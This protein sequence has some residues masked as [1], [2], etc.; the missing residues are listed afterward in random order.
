[1][2]TIKQE[3][4]R[5]LATD[6]IARTALGRGL[7]NMNGYAKTVHAEINERLFKPVSIASLVTTLSRL[8]KELQIQEQALPAINPHDI[9]IKSNLVEIS[10]YQHTSITDALLRLQKWHAEQARGFLTVIMGVREIT[11]IT[12]AKLAGDIMRLTK[13]HAPAL[14]LQ[15]LAAITLQVG[16]SAI[17]TP[18]VTYSILRRLAL[19]RINLVEVVSTHTEITLIVAERDTSE[20]IALF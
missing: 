4:L 9:S 7:L 12:D 20:V 10:F 19:R 5:C 13:P 16:E 3:L 1:M 14:A 2:R 18:S 11:V 6:D 17:S 15:N 8:G